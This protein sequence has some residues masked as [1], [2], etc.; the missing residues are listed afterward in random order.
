M[1]TPKSI[2]WISC[3]MAASNIIDLITYVVEGGFAFN[4]LWIVRLL[5]SAASWICVILTDR[6]SA[7][8][9]LVHIMIACIADVVISV[10]VAILAIVGLVVFAL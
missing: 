4:A 3:L 5:I 6:Y 8:M 2:Y 10:L 1:K 9:K 7:K